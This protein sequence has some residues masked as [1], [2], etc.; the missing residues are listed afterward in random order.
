M[1]SLCA[2]N[3]VFAPIT[4]LRTKKL[5]LRRRCVLRLAA[6]GQFYR[7]AVCLHWLV[8]CGLAYIKLRALFF[9]FSR[10]DSP[11]PLGLPNCICGGDERAQKKV[12]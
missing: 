12:Q 11:L 7:D 2:L 4:L 9:Y 8:A 10:S 3:G 5:C 6:K 1:R